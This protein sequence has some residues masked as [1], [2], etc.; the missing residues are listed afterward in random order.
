MQKTLRGIDRYLAARSTVTG[1]AGRSSCQPVLYN[2]VLGIT[3]DFLQPGQNY[4]KILEQNLDI[5]EPRFNESL[6]I[7]N[8][9]QKRKSKINFDIT[10]KCQ[11]VTK[12][13]CQT[14]HEDKIQYLHDSSFKQFC[15]PIL[16]FLIAVAMYSSEL[17]Q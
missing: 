5:G 8:T 12:D 1:V 13:E 14:D 4:I 2:E 7:T 10:T 15:L 3:K 6:V 17:R 16:V 11:H 9:I